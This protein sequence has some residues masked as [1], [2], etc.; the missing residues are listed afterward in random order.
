V[1]Q[2]TVRATGRQDGYA[3]VQALE[4]PDPL[5]DSPPAR[6]TVGSLRLV[7]TLEEFGEVGG[8]RR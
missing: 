5:K 7:V 6:V 3:P 2:A 8:V 4:A 1:S